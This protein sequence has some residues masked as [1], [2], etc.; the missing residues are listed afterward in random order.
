MIPFEQGVED[1]VR[2]AAMNFRENFTKALD[3]Q[4][5]LDSQTLIG[6]DDSVHGVAIFYVPIR[7]ANAI[8]DILD[9]LCGK[10]TDDQEI[11]RE[12]P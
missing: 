12:Y 1:A 4:P 11:I 2:A 9:E 8:S 3:G 7:F 6:C 10:G 5:G